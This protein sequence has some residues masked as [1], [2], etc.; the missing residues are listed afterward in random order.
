MV[1]VDWTSFPLEYVQKLDRYLKPSLTLTLPVVPHEIVP[2]I[3]VELTKVA[4][5]EFAFARHVSNHLDN[6]RL[7]ENHLDN[8]RLFENHLDNERLFE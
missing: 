6:E 3:Y 4:A 8:E 5:C 7:F 2:E 1:P